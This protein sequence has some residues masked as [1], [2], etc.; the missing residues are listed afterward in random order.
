MTTTTT[1]FLN[2]DLDLVSR[3]DLTA[4]VAGL[5]ARSRMHV[6]FNERVGRTYRAT[7]EL[8]GAAALPS[9]AVARDP[10]KIVRRMA[11]IVLGLPDELRAHWN[12]ATRRVF[13]LG[14]ATGDTW[15]GMPC[16]KASTARLVAD[17]DATVSISLYPPSRPARRARKKQ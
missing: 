9:S 14:F 17:L 10:D 6:L 2:V 1:D 16:L 3:R 5:A 13:D 12:D 8:G 7:L 4:L 11:G 15:L